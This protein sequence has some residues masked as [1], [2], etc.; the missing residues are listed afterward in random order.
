MKQKWYY[1]FPAKFFGVILLCIFGTLFLIGY[2]GNNAVGQSFYDSYWTD[3][4]LI[5]EAFDVYEDYLYGYKTDSELLQKYSTTN[6]NSQFTIENG[7][8]H[9]VLSTYSPSLNYGLQEDMYFAVAGLDDGYQYYYDVYYQEDSCSLYS[10]RCDHVTMYLQDPISVNDV[11]TSVYGNYQLVKQYASYYTPFMVAGV[12]GMLIVLVYEFCACGHRKEDDALHMMPMQRIPFDVVTA[13]TVVVIA[14]LL[15]IL[16][17]TDSILTSEIDYT[18]S[19]FILIS[20]MASLVFFRW[21]MSLC[22]HIKQRTLPDSLLIMRF[23]RFVWASIKA[24]PVVYRIS[25]PAT[26]WLLFE[27]LIT[28][29][30]YSSGV[31]I[32]HVCVT[33]ILYLCMIYIA[34]YAKSIFWAGKEYSQGNMDY[35]IPK[36]DLS[37]MFGLLKEHAE[38]LNS[39]NEGMRTAVDQQMK[40]ERLRTELITNV[41]HD[42]K[43]P[44]TSIINYVDLLQKEHNE[45]EEK[46]YLDVLERQSKRLK[47]L[48]D[49][50]VEASK[51]SSGNIETHMEQTSVTEIMQQALA[52]YDERLEKAS[53]LSVQN[54]QEDVSVIT[55]GRLLWRVLSNLLSN[56][57]KYSLAGTRVYIDMSETD[58]NV[59]IVLKNT[60]RE[61]L[62]V[63]PDVLME[64]F[65]RGDSSRNTEGSGLGLN[66][67]QSLMELLGGKFKIE[68]DGDL[69]KAIIQLPKM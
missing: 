43:T 68:I 20:M 10:E 60:S 38:N 17:Q 1:G 69:F 45:E 16:P 64:R 66:I 53:L 7:E 49:D 8:T 62:N 52:E 15:Y 12:L 2:G 35:Q 36:K 30:I 40:S 23:A 34:F 42:I 50:V 13:G 39:L 31:V 33:V 21:M 51:A 25:V 32:L 58:E 18:G 27:L 67:V 9:D 44:L 3:N 56:I 46:E 57:C 63:S 22:L 59:E 37:R 29:Y 4:T 5:D 24:V 54:I 48:T 6:S 41:S 47:K 61:Q 28:R 19:V 26:G 55:D 11:Y 65:T 14:V